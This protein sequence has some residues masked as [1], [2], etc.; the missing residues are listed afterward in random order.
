[1][2]STRLQELKVLGIEVA[3]AYYDEGDARQEW[4]M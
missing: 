2:S 1:M 4:Q 3:T